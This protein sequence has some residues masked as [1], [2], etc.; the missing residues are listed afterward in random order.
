MTKQREPEDALL[1]LGEA[2]ARLNHAKGYAGGRDARIYCE[3]AHYA[4]EMAIKGLIIAR[5]G[6]FTFTH[7]VAILLEEARQTGETI[8][9]EVK[10]ARRL[11][12]YGG[13]GRYAFE[14]DRQREPVTERQYEQVITPATATVNWANTRVRDILANREEYPVPGAGGPAGGIAPEQKTQGWKR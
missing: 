2:E 5:K 9:E 10:E 6:E 11:S 13:T 7:D 1:W 12:P 8:P 14:R 4:A 3:Q